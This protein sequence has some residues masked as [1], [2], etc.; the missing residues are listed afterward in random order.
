MLYKQ[1]VS[2]RKWGP[3]SAKI[4]RA[5]L[6]LFVIKLNI[7]NGFTK[8]CPNIKLETTHNL[9]KRQ[10][11]FRRGSTVKKVPSQILLIHCAIENQNCYLSPI[12]AEQSEAQ[13]CSPAW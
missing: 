6:R 3:L 2:S 7:G 13:K 9:F 4:W 8:M 5:I 11:R 1:V 10:F 12:A